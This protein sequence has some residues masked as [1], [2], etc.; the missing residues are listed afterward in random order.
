MFCC[1][2]TYFV[3]IVCILCVLW[4]SAKRECQLKLKS[5]RHFHTVSVAIAIAFPS[6]FVQTPS[7]DTSKLPHTECE[8]QNHYIAEQIHSMY[9]INLFNAITVDFF[10]K[11]GIRN[12]PSQSH[13]INIFELINFF[14]YKYLWKF[15]FLFSHLN[16]VNSDRK[17]N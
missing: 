17:L 10:F 9:G 1:L 13:K 6:F 3:C 8:Q 14:F 16:A 4:N 7:T 5:N 11:I 12:V 15:R 2:Y